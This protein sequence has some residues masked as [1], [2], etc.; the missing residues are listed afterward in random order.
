LA[1]DL[2]SRR[3]NIASPDDSLMLLK[4]TGSVPHVGGQLTRPGEP[5]YEIIRN[6]IANGAKLDTN[7]P[8]VRKIEVYP[9][10]PVVQRI[11]D[12]QQLRVLATYADNKVRDVTQEAF[13]ESGNTDVAAAQRGGLMVA[14]RRGEAPVLARYEGAYAATTLTVMGDRT[15][16]VW[17][18]PPAHNRIDLLTAAKW[19]RLKIRPSDLCSD[20]EFIRR[21]Y[22]DLTGLPPSAD[23]VRAFLADPCETRIKRDELVDRLIGSDAFVE[24]WTNKWADLLEVNRKFLGVEGAAAYRRWIRNEVAKNT[25]YDE[26]VHKVLTASGSNKENPPASYF[27]ILREPAPTMENTTHLFLAVRFNCNKCHD[28]PFERWTQDQYYQTAAYFAQVG[29]NPDPAAGGQQIG[30]TAVE[31]GKPLYEL[32]VDRKDGEVTH[33]RTGQVTAPKVPFDCRYEAPAGASRRQQLASWIT[34]KDNPYFARSYVNRLWGYMFGVGIIDP[35]DDIRAGNPA[36]NPELLDFLTQEFIKQRFDARYILRLIAKSHTYQLS[37]A[38]NPWNSDDKTNYSHALAR[39]LPAE[40]LY[41]TVYRVTGATSKFPGVPAGTRA[42]AL[43]DSGIELPSGFLATLGRPPRESACECER[44]SGLQ[45]GPV[46]ALI[47]GETIAEAIG[48]PGNE[49]AKLVA[50]EKDDTKLVE[51]IF[52]RILNRPAAKAEID[53]CLRAIHGINESHQRLVKAL[54]KRETEVAPLRVKQEKERETAIGKA[55][56]DLTT[57]EKELAPKLAELEKQRQAKI[58]Q[59]TTELQKY[60]AMLPARLAEWE[61][62]QQSQVK[63]VPLDPTTLKA[64]KDITLTKQPDLS[65]AASGKGQKGNYTFVATTDLRDITGIR[66]E[67]LADEKLPAKGPG[68]A[69]DGNF[70]LTQLEVKAAPKAKPKETQKLTLQKAV[71]D[72]TQQNFNVALALNGDPN[73]RNGWAVSPSF[74]VTHWATFETKEPIRHDGGTVLTFTLQQNFGQGFLIGRFRI[75]VTTAKQPIGLGLSEELQALV[76]LPPEKRTEAQKAAL[77]KHY[78]ESDTELQKRVKDVAESKKPLPIDPKL[79]ELRD[80]LAEVSKPVPVDPLLAQLRQDVETSKKQL[81]NQRL[82]GAQD[83]AWALINSPAFLFNR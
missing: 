81:A 28:H 8:R 71:A 20:A 6:W 5:Y 40:V 50:K 7:A 19:Q 15:E 35:I 60:E 61:K 39:R 32:I 14:A 34:S 49:L 9:L 75:S 23:E 54:E 48:D 11:G 38:T 21:V 41:D 12:R 29:L 27:K 46:M 58:A 66:L 77:M 76:A 73:S 80:N 69:K 68:L 24:Y 64:S 59:T 25:P 43:P 62:K 63:W 10:N 18:Q 83:I 4:A 37:V 53:A 70:V 26:F 82:A 65:V 47:N 13:L 42:A 45:L 56:V 31:K 55:Q 36:S 16:F 67:V 33:D 57:Y 72:F 17:Q 30:A 79:K 78:R 22:L 44:T 1:D 3:V 52:V 74:G 2:A 51:E